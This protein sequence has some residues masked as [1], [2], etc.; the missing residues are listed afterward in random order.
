MDNYFPGSSNF[1]L[2]I[3]TVYIYIYIYIYVHACVGGWVHACLHATQRMGIF[4]TWL[5]L[6]V[7][8]FGENI[9]SI[10]NNSFNYIR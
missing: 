5:F 2:P 8:G 1:K 4:N 3:C 9:I 6:K 7:I 10:F